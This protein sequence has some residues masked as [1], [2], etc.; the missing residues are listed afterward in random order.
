MTRKGEEVIKN[1][2][3]GKAIL[4]LDD[5]MTTGSTLSECAKTLKAAGAQEVWCI[6][7]ARP[8]MQ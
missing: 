8:A 5:I 3:R 1:L 2:P 6:T 4:L 7:L